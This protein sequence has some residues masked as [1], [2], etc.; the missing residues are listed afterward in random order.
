MHHVRTFDEVDVVDA[1]GTPAEPLA[2]LRVSWG[3]ILGGAIAIVAVSMILWALAAAIAFT[4]T[5]PSMDA[6][7]RTVVALWICAIVTTLIGAFV[8]GALAGYLPGNRR[9][10]IGGIHGFLAWALAF[11]VASAVAVGTAG[12]IVRTTTQVA[13]SAAETAGTTMG[14]I[15]GGPAGIDRTAES[16][17]DWL[18]Y[19]PNEASRMVEESKA[20]IRRQLRTS[21]PTAEET[22]SAIG[23][24]IDVT[25]GVYWSW[26]G[27]W[28]LAAALA[29]MGGI[30]GSKRLP[31]SPIVRVHPLHP[32]VPTPVAPLPA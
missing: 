29:L 11:V 19:S 21:G 15:A 8:G 10:G 1:A 26:F 3:S 31:P 18:G 14:G 24:A 23:R 32:D 12:G 22:K 17:L 27:T 20:D 30:A 25:A 28:F 4:A 2:G 16:V 5:G 9:P 6:V 13:T 7:L